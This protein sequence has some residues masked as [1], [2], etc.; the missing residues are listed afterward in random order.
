MLVG[1]MQL[2]SSAW[3][4]FQYLHNSSGMWLRISS[5]ALEEELKVLDFVLQQNYYYC[6]WL[7]SF[8]LVL[9]FSELNLCFGTWGRPGKLKAFLQTRGKVHE[10]WGVLSPASPHRVLLGFSLPPEV[11]VACGCFRAG[12]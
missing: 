12:A 4:G 11:G 10:G 8:P 7:D 6:V 2:T 9:Y 1:S 3:W 5:V